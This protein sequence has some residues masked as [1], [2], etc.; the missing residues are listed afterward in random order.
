MEPKDVILAAM[1]EFKEPISNGKIAELTGLEIKVVEKGM[2]KLKD[3]ELIESPKR[4]YW[5]A[6]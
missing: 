2:K 5:V 1:K 6:K 4:C 3:L